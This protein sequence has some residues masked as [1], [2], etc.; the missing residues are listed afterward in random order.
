VITGA[1]PNNRRLDLVNR[2]QDGTGAAVIATLTF[3]AGINA[4]AYDQRDVPVTPA[5]AAVAAGDILEWRSTAV[6][7]GLADPGGLVQVDIDRD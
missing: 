3:G 5:N 4:A 2:G 6:G 1:A 7:T